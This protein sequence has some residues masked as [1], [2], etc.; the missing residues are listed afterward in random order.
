MEKPSWRVSFQRT[1]DEGEPM[2]VVEQFGNRG[3]MFCALQTVYIHPDSI[4]EFVKR[5]IERGEYIKQYVA[6]AGAR[7][8]NKP[9]KLKWPH[10]PNDGQHTKALGY[11]SMCDKLYQDGQHVYYVAPRANICAECWENPQKGS[12]G[13]VE[14]I[15]RRED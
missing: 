12:D 4:D 10:Q 6:A 11:C 7:K 2:L 9:I 5:V 15:N 8:L 1:I 14:A 13:W 3:I